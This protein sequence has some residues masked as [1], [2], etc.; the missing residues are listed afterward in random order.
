MSVEPETSKQRQ[1]VF[2]PQVLCW[3]TPMP[4][5]CPRSVGGRCGVGRGCEGVWAGRRVRSGRAGAGGVGAGRSLL[6]TAPLPEEKHHSNAASGLNREPASSAIHTQDF[7]YFI[8]FQ[9]LLSDRQRV[10]YST[11]T[12]AFS[13]QEKNP[14]P[15]SIF[16][17]FLPCK[18]NQKKRN[19]DNCSASILGLQDV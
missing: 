7:Q 4:A 8:T 18:I 11:F 16:I 3:A 19:F 9:T 6:L 17:V 1:P 15:F 5:W 13:V 12:S 14:D 10:C 2:S